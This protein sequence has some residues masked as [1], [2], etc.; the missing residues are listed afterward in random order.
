MRKKVSLRHIERSKKQPVHSLS[1]VIHIQTSA[2]IRDKLTVPQRLQRDVPSIQAVALNPRALAPAPSAPSHPLNLSPVT[3]SSEPCT[4]SL[5]NHD[6]TA[7]ARAQTEMN[8]I[9]LSFLFRKN[10][11]ELHSSA[12]LRFIRI[13]TGDEDEN[14]HS[15]E[16]SLED[17]RP[18]N[19]GEEEEEG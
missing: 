6:L 4:S 11:C 16:S 12:P 3:L 5:S 18:P 17:A 15:S 14:G 1:W 10:Q 8:K 9:R 2:P 13:C 7:R 19:V